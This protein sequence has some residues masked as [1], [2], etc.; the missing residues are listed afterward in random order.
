[1]EERR[2]VETMR[3]DPWVFTFNDVCPLLC[4][5]TFK[6]RHRLNDNWNKGQSWIA[7]YCLLPWESGG[8][9]ATYK[10]RAMPACRWSILLSPPCIFTLFF[11]FL[12]YGWCWLLLNFPRGHTPSLTWSYQMNQQ[13]ISGCRVCE[14]LHHLCSPFINPPPP[15]YYHRTIPYSL[16]NPC[17]QVW[18]H[19]E[20][21]S[22]ALHI[23]QSLT[24]ADIQHSLVASDTHT[25]ALLTHSHKLKLHE[26]T[27]AQTADTYTLN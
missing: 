21:H 5:H 14:T 1:M 7:R 8:Y 10:R 23:P 18:C 16:L 19:T 2:V 15:C 26:S 27:N 4:V 22:A 11:T 9:F 17:L 3:R 24:S 13:S 6:F 20:H 12:A 25:N